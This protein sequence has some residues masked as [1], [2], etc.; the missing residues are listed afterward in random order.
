MDASKNTVWDTP[1]MDQ[2]RWWG[3]GGEDAW[4]AAEYC[5]GIPL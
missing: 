3:G 2:H 5:C 1:E 4:L